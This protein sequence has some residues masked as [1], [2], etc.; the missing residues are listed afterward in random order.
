[1]KCSR[2][3]TAVNHIAKYCGLCRRPLDAPPGWEIPE[4]D[5]H[6]STPEA[7]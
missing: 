6:G 7:P 3:G 2:C 5:S 1:M 4:H